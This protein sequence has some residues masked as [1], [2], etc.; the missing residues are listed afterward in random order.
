MKMKSSWNS[1]R[2][3]AAC[4]AKRSSV[5]RCPHKKAP[6]KVM[7]ASDLYIKEYG[8]KA[9]NVWKAREAEIDALMLGG[10]CCKSEI[11]RLREDS[12]RRMKAE[13]GSC[14][15]GMAVGSPIKSLAA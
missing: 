15:A 10:K 11:V 9:Y 1:D 8:V 2:V 12:F 13:G 4:L 7:K 14:M 5:S 3:A 6:V